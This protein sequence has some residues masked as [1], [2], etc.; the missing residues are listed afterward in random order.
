MNRNDG[1]LTNI[2][3]NIED[4]TL[5]L[6]EP[7]VGKYAFRDYYFK[8]K[9]E[10]NLSDYLFKLYNQCADIR[11]EFEDKNKDMDIGGFC[12]EANNSKIKD[13]IKSKDFFIDD[14]LSITDL[15][16][17]LNALVRFAKNDPSIAVNVNVDKEVM[18]HPFYHDIPTHYG[19]MLG[20]VDGKITPIIN[21]RLFTEFIIYI[22]NA[23]SKEHVKQFNIC[24][25]CEQAFIAKR[26][27][28]IF[29]C[30]AHKSKYNREAKKIFVLN[31]FIKIKNEISEFK[32]KSITNEDTKRKI[33]VV[34]KQWAAVVEDNIEEYRRRFMLELGNL[35]HNKVELT[36]SK[37]HFITTK[38]G[39]LKTIKEFKAFLAKQWLVIAKKYFDLGGSSNNPYEVKTTNHIIEII[40]KA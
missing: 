19:L 21:T 32:R 12:Y 16:I 17:I 39:D 11:K 20:N 34:M 22:C 5:F 37:D 18:D 13:F 33:D 31:T 23:Y 25:C 30:D 26:S 3:F 27:N 40:R 38:D 8:R 6:Y 29:C 7:Y 9:A 35:M 28:A 2:Y 10:F 1:D 4:N 14:S 15:N 36:E 24:P